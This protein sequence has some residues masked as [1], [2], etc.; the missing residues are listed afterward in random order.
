IS[1]SG[2]CGT[3]GTSQPPERESSRVRGDLG[4]CPRLVIEINTRFNRLARLLCPLPETQSCPSF[5][6]GP[7]KNL[8]CCLA[9]R[10]WPARQLQGRRR[11]RQP[12][13]VAAPH[14]CLPWFWS[15]RGAWRVWM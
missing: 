6:I 2:C 15:V 7:Q 5:L 11:S 9:P 13:P 14:P 8:L 10:L 3:G 12:S 1:S 4:A